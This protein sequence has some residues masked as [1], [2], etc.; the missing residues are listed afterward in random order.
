MSTL[1][2]TKKAL[3]NALKK[4]LDALPIPH[5]QSKKVST[6]M[7][8]EGVHESGCEITLACASVV[9]GRPPGHHGLYWLLSLKRGPIYQAMVDTGLD[10]A[11]GHFGDVFYSVTSHN[12]LESSHHEVGPDTDV[13]A[14]AAAIREQMDRIALPIARGFTSDPNAGVDFLLS[15]PVGSIRNPFT[16]AVI[17]LHLARRTDR[18]PEV[19]AAARSKPA[20]L[21]F[22]ARSDPQRDIVEPIA[23]YFAQRAEATAARAP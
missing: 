7:R 21:D 13:T 16:I 3:G 20:F 22:A 11:K 1:A 19:L 2:E 10:A 18:M 23:R 12:L 17:L 9:G 15:Q 4:R 5:L 14:V 6:K 8:L